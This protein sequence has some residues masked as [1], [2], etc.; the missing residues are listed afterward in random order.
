MIPGMTEQATNGEPLRGGYVVPEGE[1]VNAWPTPFRVAGEAYGV[2][3]RISTDTEALLPQIEALLPP[4]WVSRS[5]DDLRVDPDVEVPHFTMITHDGLEYLLMRDDAVLASSDLDVTLHVFD[6]QLRAYIALHSPHHIFVH[7]GVVGHRG[8]AIVIPGRA[9]TGK[10]TLVAELVRAGATYY[11][12]EYAVLDAEGR[13]HPYPKPLSIRVHSNVGTPHDV[14]SLGGV[15]GTESLRL[16]LIVFAQYMPGATWEPQ[17]LS[18]GE[19]VL[20]LLSNTVPAQDRPD[21]TMEALRA[22]VDGAG[23]VALAGQRGEAADVAEQI[24]ASVPE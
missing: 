14:E 11:S 3:L 18:S 19:S 10:T 5:P 13:V 7:A 6:T 21:E 20:A 12:D 17:P 1:R 4:G 22:A 9:F 15:A 24:L 8:R 23:A 16:G 2:T